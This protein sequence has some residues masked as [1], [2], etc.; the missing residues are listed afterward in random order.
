MST[1]DD[2][3][4]Y[5][6]VTRIE[7]IEKGNRRHVNWTV[8]K[9]SLEALLQDEGKTLKIFISPKGDET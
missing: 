2:K 6:Q 9:G 3:S 8:A 5:S 1:K 7:I 4:L